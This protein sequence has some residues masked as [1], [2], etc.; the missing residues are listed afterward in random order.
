MSVKFR[1][2]ILGGGT[3]GWM[4]ANL[5][6]KY[7]AQQGAQISLVESP[8]IGIIG[9]GEGSTPQLKQFFQLLDISEQEWMPACNATYK[10]GIAFHHWTSHKTNNHYFH[11]FPSPLDRQTATSFMMHS[12]MRAQGMDI[13]VQPDDFFLSTY[14]S[15]H[16]YT[17]VQKNLGTPL[18]YAYHFD[19]QRLGEF[20]RKKA[21]QNGVAHKQAKLEHVAFGE[22]GQIEHLRFDDGSQECAD[23]FID[24]SGF[25]SELLQKACKI[26]FVSFAD[27][28][29]NDSAVALPSSNSEVHRA[30][31]TATALGH[32]WAWHIPLT[33]R[34]GNGYVYSSAYVSAQDA[35]SALR[36]HIGS[37][38]SEQAARH[39][40]MKVGRV[41]EHWHKNV[42]AIGL[43]QGFIEPLEAT[44]LHLVQETLMQFIN[45]V[46]LSVPLEQQTTARA[47]FNHTI[48]QRF[49]G[50]RDYIVC[51]Y[52]LN[53]RED[54]DYWRDNRNNQVLS[55][56]LQ[57]V[58]DTWYAGKDITHILTERKMTGYYPVLSWYCILA[59]YQYFKPAT[60]ANKLNM[61]ALQQMQRA[62]AQHAEQ[63]IPLT[64]SN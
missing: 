21:V 43:S 51:H 30:Q 52:K 48:N 25:N 34:I 58:L 29:F 37:T 42:L 60:A 1:V 16:Y 23:L 39:L 8:Q 36:T 9:V 64:K 11:P 45:A 54:T 40:K 22:T 14:L 19:A 13:D 18:N 6:H 38:A 41:A 26:P 20:L 28:L 17:P 56:N 57:A 49:E 27:N 63:F 15:Q 55:E 47:E 53:T 32:G 35:E 50:I 12:N 3:A 61:S 7:W 10:T 31:T 24:C 2:C 46:S 62:F 59:G 33:N 44:A 5:L 4:S